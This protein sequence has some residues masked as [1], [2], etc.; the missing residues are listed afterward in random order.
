[1]NDTASDSV[2]K[3]VLDEAIRKC[4]GRLEYDREGRNHEAVKVYCADLELILAELTALQS[5]GEASG[6]SVEEKERME[7]AHLAF[8]LNNMTNFSYCQDC[9]TKAA[10]ILGKLSKPLPTPPKE[11]N[12]G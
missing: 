5:T 8:L 3:A 11:S 2:E 12:H 6:F 10:N 7:M 9:I 4:R 1:M